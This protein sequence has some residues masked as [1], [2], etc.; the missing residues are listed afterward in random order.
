MRKNIVIAFIFSLI[1]FIVINFLATIIGYSI[2]ELIDLEVERYGDY[3]AFIP[4]R[5][6]YSVGFFPWELLEL[7]ADM[8]DAGLKLFYMG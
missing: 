6:I 7:Y 4:F 2:A 1:V 5:M 8:S 3:P